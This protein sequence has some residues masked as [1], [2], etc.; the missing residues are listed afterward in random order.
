MAGSE[1]AGGS[2]ERTTRP[3]PLQ[4]ITGTSWLLRC[5]LYHMYLHNIAK[6]KHKQPTS[7]TRHRWTGILRVVR[8]WQ[9]A[10]TATNIH[11][12]RPQTH[13]DRHLWVSN[14]IATSPSS[15]SSPFSRTSQRASYTNCR[16]Y[17]STADAPFL[18]RSTCIFGMKPACA[19]SR[20]AIWTHLS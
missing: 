10:T 16:Y 11:S 18:P 1:L 5:R 17:A 4:Q 9:Q 7:C 14:A 12:I 13:A 8:T 15:S 2:K 3:R 19:V 20:L 6:D